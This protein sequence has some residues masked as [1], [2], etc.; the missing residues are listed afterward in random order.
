M[1]GAVAKACL[2]SSPAIM[3]LIGVKHEDISWQGVTRGPAIIKTLNSFQRHTNCIGVVPVRGIGRIGQ[4]G[5]KRLYA[6][7]V[8]SAGRV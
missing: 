6:V 1:K 4:A 5:V 2:G 8:V 7:E 3:Q